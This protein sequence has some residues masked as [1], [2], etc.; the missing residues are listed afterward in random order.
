MTGLA[1]KSLTELQVMAAN[2]R[3]QIARDPQQP[4]TELQDIEW[5]IEKRH[6]KKDLPTANT[7]KTN[8]QTSQPVKERV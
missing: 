5:E 2:L 8:K 3:E 7:S 4:R 1:E 6:W